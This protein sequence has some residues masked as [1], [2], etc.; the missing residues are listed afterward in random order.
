[1]GLAKKLGSLN[2]AAAS[3]A[4]NAQQPLASGGYNSQNIPNIPAP[5]PMTST[6]Q[7][8]VVQVTYAARESYRDHERNAAGLVKPT[9]PHSTNSDALRINQLVTEK[10]WRIVCLRE[11]HVFYTQSE[12]QALVDRACRHDYRALM[13]DW[14]LPTIDMATD[15]AVMGLYDIVLFIDDS[16]SMAAVDAGQEHDGM[17][18]FQVLRELTKTISFWATLMDPDGIVL[19]FFNHPLEQEGNGLSSQRAVDRLFEIVTPSGSTPLGEELNNKI[20]RKIVE[21]FLAPS[22]TERLARPVL[23][24]TITDG[25]PNN[26]VTVVETISRMRRACSASRYGRFAMAYSFAQIGT[27]AGATAFLKALDIHPEIGDTIDCTSEYSIEWAE[28]GNHPGFT[29]SAW[30]V[31]LLIGP[32]DPAYDQSDEVPDAAAAPQKSVFNF[33]S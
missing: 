6:E 3:V 30:L 25:Q 28:T 9:T 33:G 23:I 19:R 22:S 11:I 10:M 8:D 4:A 14:N 20:F 15:I 13:R 5:P 24:I 12:L 2:T 17:T 18:R 1:M 29:P 32:I 21:P 26:G 16:G 7:A 27:D 31:K